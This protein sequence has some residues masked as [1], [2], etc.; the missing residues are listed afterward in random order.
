MDSKIP[1]ISGGRSDDLDI[2]ALLAEIIDD[3]G[4]DEDAGV[5][6]SDAQRIYSHGFTVRVDLKTADPGVHLEKIGWSAS[7]PEWV[8]STLKHHERSTIRGSTFLTQ[9]GPRNRSQA[10]SVLAKLNRRVGTCLYA[11]EYNRPFNGEHFIILRG[12]RDVD[13]K[14]LLEEHLGLASDQ[15]Q[16]AYYLDMERYFVL[17]PHVAFALAGALDPHAVPV[18]GR[19]RTSRKR[20]LVKDA[21][22]PVVIRSRAKRMAKLN[23]YRIDNGATAQFKVEISLK[24]RRQNKGH[25]NKDDIPALDAV[26]HQLI[27]EHAL[28]PASK[29]ERWEPRRP[30]QW[31]RDGRLARLSGKA[32]RGRRVS[33]QRVQAARLGHTP[34]LS[35][36]VNYPTSP[37]TL[38]TPY[39]IRKSNNSNS[40]A[41][42]IP[43]SRIATDISQ[44]PG[45]LTEVVL[46]PD[47]DPVSLVE[48][49]VVSEPQGR[50]AVSTLVGSPGTGVD[51]WRSL[52]RLIEHNPLSEAT[53]TLVVVVDTSVILAIDDLVVRSADDSFHNF[54]R[55]P[56]FDPWWQDNWCPLPLYAKAMAA[57]L[58]PMLAELRDIC[59]STGLKVVLVT[60]DARPEHGRGPLLPTH[61]FRD[62]RVRSHIGDAG[63]YYAHLRYLVETNDRG[64]ATWVGMLKDEGQGLP[65]RVLWGAPN[66]A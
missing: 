25:F 14:R 53:A 44:Y 33:E 43:W 20:W 30:P 13:V 22:F 61:F 38:P 34:L 46:S 29:P 2:D 27:E 15:Y 36:C 23:I 10:S 35:F 11:V 18:A 3:V 21:E 32:Y 64:R 24:G 40:S 58:S 60:V 41:A 26:L 42:S 48:A 45:Y 17:P 66:G 31:P 4:L 56:F 54:E 65:G 50:V 28:E 7:S 57:L 52:A 39:L 55:G 62:A 49:V 5:P 37:L 12:V 19:G 63:R 51:G 6:K 16:L 8:H 1:S 59:E 47:Q 9:R